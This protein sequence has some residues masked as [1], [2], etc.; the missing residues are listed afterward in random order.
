MKFPLFLPETIDFTKALNENSSEGLLNLIIGRVESVFVFITKQQDDQL[1]VLAKT[2]A[3]LAFAIETIREKSICVKSGKARIDVGPSFSAENLTPDG[4]EEIGALASALALHSVN[5]QILSYSDALSSCENP[6]DAFARIFARH[7]ANASKVVLVDAYALDWSLGTASETSNVFRTFVL[8][9]ARTVHVLSKVPNFGESGFKID[10]E[11]LGP[12]N[13]AHFLAMLR[14]KAEQLL[15]N[16]NFLG[17][18][19]I[20]LY[21]KHGFP[22]DRHMEI[23]FAN[24]DQQ[25]GKSDYFSLGN[26]FQT[27]SEDKFNEGKLR[28]VAQVYPSDKMRMWS[29]LHLN[30]T[31][32]S[33]LYSLE[34]DFQSK[35]IELQQKRKASRSAYG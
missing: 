24:G 5:S 9:G 28:A 29:W 34:I 35:N 14:Q 10:G 3:R 12:L 27:F 8:K 26:G 21:Q 33:L 19:V 23:T 30:A 22:H 1:A 16:S 25:F 32:P 17:K 13:E 4:I 7:L 15:E 31:A 18:L 6:S 20:D 2:N 11:F